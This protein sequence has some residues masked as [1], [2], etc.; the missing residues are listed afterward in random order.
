MTRKNKEK[1]LS[2]RKKKPAAKRER[3]REKGER[4]KINSKVLLVECSSVKRCQTRRQEVRYYLT[5]E[6][7]E[8]GE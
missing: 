5:E 7:S 4:K 6:N 8:R 2:E 3:E 1:N